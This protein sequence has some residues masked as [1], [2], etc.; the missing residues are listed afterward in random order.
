M[1]GILAVAAL[2]GLSGVAWAGFH[3]ATTSSR[4]AI[5]RITVTGNQ[6]LSEAEVRIMLPVTLGDNVFRTDLDAII[7][8]LRQSPWIADAQARRVLPRTIAVEVRERRAVAIVELGGLYL[9]DAAGHPFKRATIET[10]EGAGLPIITGLSRARFT[11]DPTATEQ[12]LGAALAALEAWRGNAERPSI[13]ELHIGPY[14][15]LTFRT[16]DDAIA[17]Q[18]GIPGGELP[19]RLQAFDV[20]WSEMAEGESLRARS[21]HVDPRSDHVTVAFAKDE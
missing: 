17:I 8:R 16:Y 18:L 14:G 12:L 13:G 9:V 5:Q 2:C 6:R 21:V 11:A 15:A 20:A 7:K 10:G 4:F 19:L 3:F 1:T